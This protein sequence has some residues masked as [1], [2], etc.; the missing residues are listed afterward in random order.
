M[1]E[2]LLANERN[3][4]GME[5]GV[6]VAHASFNQAVRHHRVAVSREISFSTFA[7]IYLTLRTAGYLKAWPLTRGRGDDYRQVLFPFALE[8]AA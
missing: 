2:W 3:L 1:R 8:G 5:I 4:A 6:R 7:R